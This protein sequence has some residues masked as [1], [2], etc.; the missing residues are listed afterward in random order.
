MA[1]PARTTPPAAPKPRAKPGPVRWAIAIVLLALAA[2]AGWHTYRVFGQRSVVNHI[3]ELGGMV[4]YDFEDP[5]DRDAKSEQSFIASIL[6]NDYAHDIVNVNL[7]VTEK[8]SLT[9]EDLKKVSQLS[10]AHTLEAS[11]GSEITD[12]GLLALANMP[13]LRKLRLSQFSQVTDAGLAV[14]SRLPELR[15]LQLISLPKITDEGLS[16]LAE[17]K[18]LEQLTINGCPINGT[19][20]KNLQ[21]KSLTMLD[22]STCQIND[23]ALEHL[24]GASELV[25]LSLAQNKITGAGLS[26]LKGL[27]KLMRLR[28]SE[29]PLDP[30]AALPALKSLSSLE[31]I[32]LSGVSTIGRKEGEELAKA[33]PKCDITIT[34]GS[35]NPEDGWSFEG[36]TG[37]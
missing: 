3:D 9:D 13:R 16:H 4:M 8:K 14:L 29:N 30:A 17:L 28:L 10:A 6:G 25:E 27:P 35:Y 18:N 12:D 36:Q 1:E 23:A 5:V 24:S 19:C 32:T 15:E 33:L 20:W 11:K 34:G 7:S 22:A 21:S 37:E 26:H 31:M 2:W